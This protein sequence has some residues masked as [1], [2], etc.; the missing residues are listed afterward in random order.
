MNSTADDSG[1]PRELHGPENGCPHDAP[2]P[3]PLPPNI[4]GR[5][6]G[7]LNVCGSEPTT[8]VGLYIM[9]KTPQL[10]KPGI[11]FVDD[12]EN[13]LRALVRLF[14]D[15]GYEVLTATSGAQGLELL[16][17][18]E[19]AVVVSDLAMPG[20][21]GTEFLRC[22][23][24]VSPDTVRIILTGFTD[25]VTFIDYAVDE[26]VYECIAKPW[27]NHHLRSSVNDAV[28]RYGYTKQDR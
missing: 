19:I 25:P 20:M 14:E 10:E 3:P 13:V 24:E 11:L 28:A 1:R 8:V 16:K 6:S 26:D 7:G 2:K 4:H 21:R 23:E 18:R 12:D 22:V 9:D 15:E 5:P 27:E 17:G